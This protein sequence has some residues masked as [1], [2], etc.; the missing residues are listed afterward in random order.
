MTASSP[1]TI[2]QSFRSIEAAGAHGHGAS[3]RRLLLKPDLDIF[4][5]VRFP[6][7]EWALSISSTEVL[8]DQ[9]FLLTNGLTCQ[10]RN[11]S[12]EVVATP[13]TD[14]LLF[15]T[16]LADLI[17]HL[18]QAASA[19][20]ST[21]VRRLGAWRRM[22]GRGLPTGLTP[23][24]RLGL[25][26]EL[27]VLREILLPALRDTAVTSWSGPSG[28]PKDFELP[29][30]A[31]EVK[32]VSRKDP[33]RCRISN[34]EQ[35]NSDGLRHLYLIHQVA[36]TSPEGITLVELVDEI[37]EHPDVRGSL[38]QFEDG[39][40]EVGW[41]DAHRDQYNHDRYVLIRRRC[42][43][44]GDGFPRILAPDLPSGVSR[45]SYLV[46]LS[47]CGAH[48]VDEQKVREAIMETAEE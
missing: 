44:V 45:V 34:E 27:L 3:R 28:S 43:D 36:G 32:T 23:E 16:L 39:L 5:E 7:R 13:D 11:G 8:Q 29:A 4:T 31:A 22:L 25:Y 40:L 14:R 48:Q 24:A 26:G 18:D 47:I 38:A 2:E 35:L 17:G 33:D 19:S 15:C 41:L 42:F 37:R 30:M 9:E 10:A 6:S 21:V 20:A 1:H 46:D 12:V